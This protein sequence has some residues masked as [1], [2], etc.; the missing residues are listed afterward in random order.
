MERRR[1]VR[2]P[3]AS[4]LG[5]CRTSTATQSTPRCARCRRSSRCR[6]SRTRF[7][8]YNAGAELFVDLLSGEAYAASN[9]IANDPSKVRATVFNKAE[10]YKNVFKKYIPPDTPAL[11]APDNN[12]P[13]TEAPA[14]DAAAEAPTAEDVPPKRVRR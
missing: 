1:R 9:A 6:S 3:L 8:D 2:S 5:A 11:T 14:A 13:A 10:V 12:A 7:A 4:T